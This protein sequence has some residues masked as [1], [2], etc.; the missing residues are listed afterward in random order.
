MLDL[1]RG[2]ERD[3][4]S[5]T[6]EL[7][8]KSYVF[9]GGD[10]VGFVVSAHDAKNHGVTN[11]AGGPERLRIALAELVG[12][13]VEQVAVAGYQSR[14]GGSVIVGAECRYLSGL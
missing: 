6:A 2:I 9:D 7:L 4:L 12:E 8:P 1:P 14:C 10:A 3:A 13:V 11:S 5:G